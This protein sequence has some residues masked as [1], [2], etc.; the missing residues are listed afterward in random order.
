ML[1]SAVLMTLIIGVGY[2]FFISSQRSFQQGEA[3]Y[4]IQHEAQMVVEQLKVDLLHAGKREIS[5]PTIVG[6]GNS[7]SFLRF[8]DVWD[9]THP[10]LTKVTYNYSPSAKTV[11]RIVADG[12]D[13]GT[14]EVGE[15]ITEFNLMPYFLNGR[16]YF[17]VEV[18]AKVD[19]SATTSYDMEVILKTSI[20]SRYENNLLLQAGWIN[21]PQTVVK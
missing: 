4:K 8:Y 20:E 1:I 18:A 9:S 14:R 13:K 3:K 2:K 10:I 15:G 19:K 7:W 12:P 16:Y 5:D 21:N 11:T 6:S 17:R